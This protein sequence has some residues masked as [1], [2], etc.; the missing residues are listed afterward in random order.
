VANLL[1]ARGI[2]RQR[3]IGVRL[4]LGA[5]R[6]R[7]VRQ[8]L[9]ESLLLAIAAAAIAYGLSRVALVTTLSGAIAMM[10][11]EMSEN[12]PLSV[13]PADWRVV[14][15][16][17]GG[18]VL[19]T[20]LFGMAP[21]FQATRLELVRT[22]RGELTRDARPNRARNGLIAVQ[23]GASALLL[24]SAS[25]FLRSAFVVASEDIGLRTTDTIVVE[26]ANEAKRAARS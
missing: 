11:P 17:V 1:L 13:P 14:L 10:P 15:F 9:T 18:A 19:S 23:V 6:A 21:A 3:E 12:F 4:S 7:I 8:L 25:V 2:A 22:M 26:M 24:I 16:L 5:S 20:A